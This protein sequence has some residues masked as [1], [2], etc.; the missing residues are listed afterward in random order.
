MVEVCFHAKDQ[1]RFPFFQVVES[2][3]GGLKL[4]DIGN[5]ETL[6]HHLQQVDVIAIGFSILIEEGVRPKIP[7]IFVNQ[8]P[9]NREHSCT[10]FLCVC[11]HRRHHPTPNTQYQ[12]PDLHHRGY[13]HPEGRT[14]PFAFRFYADLAAALLADGLAD[15]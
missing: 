10:V 4:D 7:R 12:T 6:E 15:A 9:L 2:I 1:V 5:V 14:F 3:Q 8:G 11:C 13:P